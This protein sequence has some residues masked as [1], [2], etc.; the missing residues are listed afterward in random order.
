MTS[1]SIHDLKTVL[2]DYFPDFSDRLPALFKVENF[3]EL[4]EDYIF[5]NFELKQL[6][7]SKNEKLFKQYE[8]TLQDLEEELLSYLNP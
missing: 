6:S 8:E 2:S 5:C 7:L 4:A 3:R 1:K